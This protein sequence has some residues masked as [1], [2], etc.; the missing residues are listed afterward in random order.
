MKRNLFDSGGQVTCIRYMLWLL[1][2]ARASRRKK[3]KEWVKNEL[4]VTSKEEVLKEL[5]AVA[6]DFSVRVESAKGCVECKAETTDFQGMLYGFH[7]LYWD[8]A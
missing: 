7:Q 1:A 2:D 5:A 8:P 6:E 4:A 3:T